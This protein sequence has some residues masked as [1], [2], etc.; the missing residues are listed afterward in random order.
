MTERIKS[1]VFDA[2]NVFIFFDGSKTKQ[3]VMQTLNVDEKVLNL[4]WRELIPKLGTG[5][6]TEEQFWK[7]FCQ[8]TGTEQNLPTESLLGREYRKGVSVDTKI[9]DIV[10]SLKEQGLVVAIMSNTIKPHADIN[11]EQGV[12]KEFSFRALSHEVGSRKP[13]ERIYLYTLEALGLPPEAVLLVD[14]LEENIQK[15]RE[16]GM[17]GI[18]YKNIQQLVEDLGGVGLSIYL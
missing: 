14:D 18:V 11:E 16:L 8:V 7:Y 4:L 5:E 6:I 12:Y 9:L 2:G 3:D 15:A 1:V 13:N 17:K 10:R